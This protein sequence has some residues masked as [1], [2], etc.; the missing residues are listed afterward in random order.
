[1]I[2]G[3]G[4]NPLKTVRPGQL[5]SKGFTLIEMLAVIAIIGILGSLLFAVTSAARR[6][7]HIDSAKVEVR[8]LAKAWKA[9]WLVYEQWPNFVGGSGFYEMTPSRMKVLQGQDITDN[10]RGLRFLDVD[11]SK[12]KNS[13]YKDPWGHVYKVRFSVPTVVDSSL[14]Y[15][16][17]VWFPNSQRYKYDEL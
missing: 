12:W 14:Y 9:Y 10:P 11:R 7:A 6:R 5:K 1:M 3:P 4:S 8:E 15:A 16:T 13:G 17:T 2:S